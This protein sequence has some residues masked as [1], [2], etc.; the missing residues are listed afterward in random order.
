[1]PDTAHLAAAL[2]PSAV[3]W[4]LSPVPTQD[5][6]VN[7][8]LTLEAGEGRHTTLVLTLERS[9]ARAFA[10]AVLAASGDATERRVGPLQV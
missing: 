8:D 6:R 4:S 5:G 3:A 9:E 2:L 1:M 7:L 10:R